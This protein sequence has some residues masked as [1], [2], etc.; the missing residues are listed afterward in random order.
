MRFDP[1][2][3]Q[4]L[5]D[6]TLAYF[7]LDGV[8]HFTSGDLYVSAQVYETLPD[9]H[10]SVHIMTERLDATPFTGHGETL[11]EACD[12]VENIINECIKERKR[13]HERSVQQVR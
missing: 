11:E 7:K 6:L 10:V 1:T 3:V 4:R 12:H 8:H 9:L 2:T 13:F 5:K